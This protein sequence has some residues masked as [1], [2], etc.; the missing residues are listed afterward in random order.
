MTVFISIERPSPHPNDLLAMKAC[1]VRGFPIFPD[2]KKK[3]ESDF[4]MS[5][6]SLYYSPQKHFIMA[7]E[8]RE[9]WVLSSVLAVSVDLEQF[10]PEWQG[11]TLHLVRREA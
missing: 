2:G 1:G 11:C 3:E 4:P 8:H 6:I 9:R 5:G 7:S 10:S